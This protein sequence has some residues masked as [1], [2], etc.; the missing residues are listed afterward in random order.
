MLKSTLLRATWVLCMAASGQAMAAG[1]VGT[2][3]AASCTEAAL[4]SALAGGGVVDFNCGAAAHTIVFTTGK[5]ISSPT[6]INGGNLIILDGSG[7]VRHFW[8]NTN[9]ANL[10]LDGLTLINGNATGALIP[11]GGAVFANTNGATIVVTNTTFSN[12]VA[13][14][15]GGAI[16]TH[17]LNTLII[18]G[19]TFQNNMASGNSAAGG[20]IEAS[21][22]FQITNSTFS[23]N[24]ATSGGGAISAVAPGTLAHVT[25]ANNSGVA[26][27]AA[28]AQVTLQNT[29]IASSVASNC[30]GAGPFLAQGNNLQFGGTTPNSCG[31]GIPTVDPQL[32]ALAN[33]GGPTYTMALAPTSPAVDAADF[34]LCTATDQRGIA[35]PQ[36]AGCDIGAFES[37]VV[38]NVPS[39]AIPVPVLSPWA[40]IA[41]CG[42]LSSAAVFARRTYR[43]S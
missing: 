13:P 32:S 6:T 37:T 11:Q 21:D 34:S 7:A 27:L 35:R 10:T 16:R 22:F 14:N 29:I 41:L 31:A 33:N 5:L 43:K 26:A 28:S 36:G 25:L 8:V 3:T 38:I 20:A 9:G 30:G 1:T 24:S 12:N 18:R 15:G 2:G 4:D 39:A 17:S 23:S 40:L 42:L 19:S